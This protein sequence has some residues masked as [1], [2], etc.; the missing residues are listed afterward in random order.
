MWTPRKEEDG[1]A[2]W[3]WAHTPEENVDGSRF[4]AISFL[5][6]RSDTSSRYWV[7]QGGKA[8]GLGWKCVCELNTCDG[9]HTVGV[10]EKKGGLKPWKLQP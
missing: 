1:T 4:G 2:A 8:L 5:S 9:L 10:G 7:R 3:C 6:D